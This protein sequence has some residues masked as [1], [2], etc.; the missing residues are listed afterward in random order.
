MR[1][2]RTVVAEVNQ[3]R[4]ERY[5]GSD[6]LAFALAC[7]AGA[8]AIVLFLVEK[9]Q[10]TVV[11]FLMLMGLLLIY[12]VLHFF[13]GGI[14]RI[15]LSTIVFIG[16]FML[17]W[18]V[19][20]RNKMVT[21]ENSKPLAQDTAALTPQSSAPPQGTNGEAVKRQHQSTPPKPKQMETPI[22]TQDNSVHLDNGSKIEQNSKGDCSPNIV[23]GSNNINCVPQSAKVSFIPEYQD[24]Q[25]VWSNEGTIRPPLTVFESKYKVVV[26]SVFPITQLNI[27][28]IDPLLVNMDCD[29]TSGPASGTGGSRSGRGGGMCS[30]PSASEN[31]G[32]VI[33][34]FSQ[35]PESPVIPSYEC[36]G[37]IKCPH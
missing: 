12:P 36:I 7:L 17:G 18:R 19:W 11:F 32:V 28:V 4:T 6:K 2:V 14:G 10:F 20:P 21:G 23:G 25:T 33:L 30:I 9:T 13:K 34:R 22:P 15:V 37:G 29:I 8:L 26:E 35:K 24:R 16:T 1:S 27:S 5:S 31:A 3:T